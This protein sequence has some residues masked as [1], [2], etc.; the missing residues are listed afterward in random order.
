MTNDNET[1]KKK[2]R[3]ARATREKILKSAEKLFVK[4]GYN[5]VTVDEIAALADINKRMLY[6]YFGNKEQL[7]QEVLTQNLTRVFTIRENMDVQRGDPY[8]RAENLIRTYFQFLRKHPNFVRLITWE[9]L[10]P[11]A[12]SKKMSADHT[13]AG[14]ESLVEIL[15]KGDGADRFEPQIDGRK[16]VWTINAI[17]FNFFT[18]R[19]LAEAI[20]KEELSSDDGL[21]KILAYSIDLCLRNPANSGKLTRPTNKP[22]ADKD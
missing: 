5:G 2:T 9:T 4:R 3:D 16:L 19:N 15:Q 7:Y 1:G 14:I 11:N 13:A 8:Q 17:F 12:H 22:P 21:D 18:M 20:W 6:V 10:N